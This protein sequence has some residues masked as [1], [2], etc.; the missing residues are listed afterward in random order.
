MCWWSLQ[1][2]VNEIDLHKADVLGIDEEQKYRVKDDQDNIRRRYNTA[3]LFR[4]AQPALIPALTTGTLVL[5]LCVRTDAE[6][7]Q[8]RLCK[9][10]RSCSV[11]SSSHVTAVLN[12]RS[13]VKI[14]RLPRVESLGS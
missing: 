4:L 14:P 13:F 6:S 1:K 5:L 3:R 2:A 10:R 7:R 11:S 12:I 9:F 8:A